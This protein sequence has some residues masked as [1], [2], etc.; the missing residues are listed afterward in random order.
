MKMPKTIG[1]TIDL[2]YT[3]REER[4]V[5]EAAIRGIKEK[6][7]AL[8]SHL[9]SN[10]ERVGLDGA[11]GKLATAAIKR[12]TVAEVTDWDAFYKYIAK[13]K[14]WDLMQKRASITSLRER[15][16]DNKVVPG[17]QPKVIESLSLNKA[18]G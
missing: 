1:E 18:G 7:D 10:F 2:M 3:L 4:K 8:E 14:A 15:W 13:N 17:V 6:E 16:D 12:S 11:K 5:H 9:M